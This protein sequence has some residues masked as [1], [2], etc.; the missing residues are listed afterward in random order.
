MGFSLS[1]EL[2]RHQVSPARC[3]APPLFGG[4]SQE[5]FLPNTPKRLVSLSSIF[6][7]PARSPPLSL[8]LFSIGVAQ[9]HL[10]DHHRPAFAVTRLSRLFRVSDED[11]HQRLPLPSPLRSADELRWQPP[12]SRTRKFPT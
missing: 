12:P 7:S 8:S 4:Q 1:G 5:W 10:H 2:H 3:T 11:Q 6:K 9:T